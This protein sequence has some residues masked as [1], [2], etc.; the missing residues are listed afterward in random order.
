[1]KHR[2]ECHDVCWPDV[3]RV[4]THVESE[5][6]TTTPGTTEHNSC[7]RHQNPHRTARGQEPA[8]LVRRNPRPD[9]TYPTAL[10]HAPVQG[11]TLS[12]PHLCSAGRLRPPPHPTYL[13]PPTIAPHPL[14]SPRSTTPSPSTRERINPRIPSPALSLS[15]LPDL[16]RPR[17][18]GAR[19]AGASCAH[20]GAQGGLQGRGG[21]PPARAAERP[22]RAGAGMGPRRLRVGAG[23]QGQGLGAAHVPRQQLR[24]PRDQVR[25]E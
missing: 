23:G 21:V 11:T 20:D 6:R 24:H 13:Q 7:P 14:P 16:N 12:F 25:M 1:L 2:P 5:P 9:P 10:S 8:P 3:V 18:P 4:A 22:V 15:L 19:V 17:V